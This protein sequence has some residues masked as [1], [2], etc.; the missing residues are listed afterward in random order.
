M[1]RTAPTYYALQVGS[2]WGWFLGPFYPLFL[3][4]LGL[5][6]TEASAVLAT[7]FITT[8]LFE[9][10]TGA[11]ADLYGRRVSFLASCVVRTGAFLLYYFADGFADCLVAEAVDAIGTALSSGALEAW[12]IDEMEAEGDPRPADRLFASANVWMRSVMAL[13]GIVGTLVATIDIYLPWLVGAAGYATTFFFALAFMHETRLPNAAGRDAA[14][15]AAQPGSVAR[16]RT[17][18]GLVAAAGSNLATTLREAVSEVLASPTVR[19]LCL[20]TVGTAF[21]VMPVYFGW[22]AFLDDMV[23]G[24]LLQLGFVWAAVS[25]ASA[26][27]SA[28]VPAALRVADRPQ[29]LALTMA[30]R[31]AGIVLVALATGVG[32]ALLGLILLETG[33]GLSHPIFQSWV[34]EH[35]GT[36]RRA[37]VLSLVQMSFT[38]GGAVGLLLLGRLAELQGFTSAWLIAGLLLVGLAPV[39]LLI[40]WQDL[41]LAATVEGSSEPAEGA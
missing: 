37:T 39:F 18:A 28:S 16:R 21:G 2:N 15:T 14:A 34:N 1:H 30:L 20:L 22:P 4:S 25:L 5:S 40:R 23:G 36:E 31:G 13:A 11:V 17:L 3:L 35:V 12:V 26:L 33:L 7:Y 41:A 24:D 8:L 38:S 9:V 29:L 19:L 6:F 27:G 10:P 32:Q